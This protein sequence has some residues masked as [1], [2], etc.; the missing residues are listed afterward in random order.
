MWGARRGR[1]RKVSGKLSIWSFSPLHNACPMATTDPGDGFIEGLPES[2][3]SLM[4]HCRNK[5]IKKEF[6]VNHQDLP[7]LQNA[8]RVQPLP[9]IPTSSSTLVQPSSWSPFP[10]LAAT[11]HMP[12]DK[13]LQSLTLL[14]LCLENLK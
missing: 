4:G 10:M 5:I 2:V 9:S 6:S 8:F 7:L 11:Q 13:S 12:E 1:R 3:A 14:F